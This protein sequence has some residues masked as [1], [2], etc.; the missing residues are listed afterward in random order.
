MRPHLFLIFAV[1]ASS[2]AKKSPI[3]YPETKKEIVIDSFFGQA[4][5]DPYRWLEDDRSAV[6]K[7]IEQYAD[8]FAF[9][10]YN[11]GF[12]VLPNKKVKG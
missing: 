3:M 2:C 5:E 6:N 4:V 12:K 1:L 7:T 9:T 8:I 10:L 11:M